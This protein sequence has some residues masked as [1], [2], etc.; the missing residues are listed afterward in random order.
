M[1]SLL[2]VLLLCLA[3]AASAGHGLMNSFGGI[4]WLPSVDTL[5]D[6]VGYRLQRAK[7]ALAEQAA[8][9]P[10]DAFALAISQ[11]RHR[12]AAAEAAVRASEVGLMREALAHWATRLDAAAQLLAQ[13]PGAEGDS[14]RLRLANELLEQQYIVATDYL[15]L[16]RDTRPALQQGFFDLAAA[17]YAAVRE[18]LRPASREGLFF[19]EEEIRW[20]REQTRA[21]DEQGL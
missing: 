9:T 4:A 14:A 21:A 19:R 12:L 1:K 6:S 7:D 8:A 20:A 3:Q 2:G 10:G 15:D 11:S 16:P 17:R 18:T 13:L 5:P